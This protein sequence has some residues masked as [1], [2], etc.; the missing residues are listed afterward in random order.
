MDRIEKGEAQGILAWHPDRL[1][2]NSVDAGRIIWFIDTGLIKALR[3]PTY[4]FEP[5]AQGKFNLSIM[6]SQSKYYADN[7]GENIRRGHRQKLKNGI[8]PGFAPLG[9]Q[10]D[11]ATR[12]IMFDPHRAPLVHKMFE[13]YATGEYTIERLTDTVNE[14]GLIS[15]DGDPLSRAQYHRLLRNPIYHGVIEYNG[16]LYEGRHEPLIPKALFDAVGEIVDRRSK[17][18]NPKFKPYLYR[19]LFR[20]GECGRLITTETQKGFN[21]L[22]CSKWKVNCSQPYMREDLMHGQIDEA[23]NRIA[24]PNDITDWLVAEF[25]Q[26]QKQDCELT[27][28]ARENIRGQIAA[29]DQKVERLMTLYLDNGI[30]LEEYRK[31]KN[32]LVTEKSVL[33]GHLTAFEHTRSIPFEPALRFIK[34][35][36]QATIVAQGENLEQKRDFLRKA[37]SNFSLADRKLTFEFRKPWQLVADQRFSEANEKPAP[38]LGAGFPTEIDLLAKMRRR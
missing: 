20:C 5:T 27:K 13:L 38:V 23:I 18:R 25:A 1:S 3:F 37:A 9:Y 24:V 31:A 35:L 14:L 22:R 33:T 28:N 29:L 19:G 17:P 26:E 2:R 10:N 11:K 34:A 16:E 4:V 21:Y 8:W 15:R 30:S 36:K 32:Q 7:L 6:L 12:T